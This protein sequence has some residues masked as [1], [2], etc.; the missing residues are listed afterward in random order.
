[1]MAFPVAFSIASIW[2]HVFLSC[3]K[4]IDIPLR[5]KR[6]VRPGKPCALSTETVCCHGRWDSTDAVDVRFNIWLL[7]YTA[8]CS[9]AI[10]HQGQIIVHDHVDLQHVDSAGNHVRGNE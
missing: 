5:P 6:P 3:T 10:I 1:M 2:D 8:T 9:L 7:V 4:L